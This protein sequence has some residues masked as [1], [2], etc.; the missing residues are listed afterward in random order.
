[1]RPIRLQNGVN[2]NYYRGV[3]FFSPLSTAAMASKVLV[4]WLKREF[5]VDVVKA[6]VLYGVQKLGYDQP[7]V[8]QSSSLVPSPS[9][10]MQL[11][12]CSRGEKASFPLAFS[13]RLQDK[14]WGGKDW[15]RGYRVAYCKITF[16]QIPQMG[17]LGMAAIR[18]TQS[19][20]LLSY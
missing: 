4:K 17:R 20:R 7:T 10:P 8:D 18:L 5:S 14:S 2:W 6:A 15:E 12:S 1:M 16:L 3:E 13:P 9:H 11:L 19:S